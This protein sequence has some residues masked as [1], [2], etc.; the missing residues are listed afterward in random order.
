MPLSSR[1]VYRLYIGLWAGLDIL[2]P[3][4]C[5]GCERRGKRW[6]E[7]CQNETHIISPPICNRC[8]HPEDVQGICINC[9][10]TPPIFTGLR[11]WAEYEGSLRNAIIR[12]K[13][14]RDISLGEV[15]SRYLAE[16]IINIGWKVNMVV[17][18][19]LGVARLTERGYNQAALLA[20]PLALSTEIQYKPNVL[21]RIIE[22]RT[23]VGLTFEQR[24][25]NVEG[26]F[27]ADAHQVAN[28]R[29]LLVDDVAT[30]GATLDACASALLIAGATDVYGLTLARAL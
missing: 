30:S 11:S 3:P 6:C 20:M 27:I 2:Y 13:Y 22:T 25:V 23:Q 28:K 19:P 14:Y 26:A 15:L 12:L 24:K 4:Y 9:A 16:C 17:P 1:S 29:I 10:S 8:G 18:V 7:S 5:G 21:K